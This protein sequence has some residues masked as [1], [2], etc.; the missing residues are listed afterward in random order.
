MS[1]YF[2]EKEYNLN[3]YS[4]EEIYINKKTLKK[5]T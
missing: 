2:D 1:I 5:F 4:I 3:E